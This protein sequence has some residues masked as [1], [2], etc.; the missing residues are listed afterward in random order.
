[1]LL[2]LQPCAVGTYIPCA[3][4]SY[5]PCAAGSYIPCAAG[6]YI[7]CAVGT[8]IPCAVGTY[9]PC[10]VS[11][12]RLHRKQVLLHPPLSLRSIPMV[13]TKSIITVSH[14]VSLVDTN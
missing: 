13:S 6:S 7:P 1:M 12:H 9:I 4:G 5:I 8:Y 2:Q 3:V 14:I 11:L 10:H